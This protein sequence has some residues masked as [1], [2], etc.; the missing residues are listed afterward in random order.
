MLSAVF[1]R[2]E[3]ARAQHPIAADETEASCLPPQMTPIFTKQSPPPSKGLWTDGESR[4]PLSSHPKHTDHLILLLT[5]GNGRKMHW[6][7]LQMKTFLDS[8]DQHWD[9]VSKKP[10]EDGDEAVLETQD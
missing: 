1:I 2:Y 10:D 3:P 8:W 4:V 7:V 5:A 9:H 6:Q